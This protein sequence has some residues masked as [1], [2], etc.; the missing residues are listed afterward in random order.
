MTSVVFSIGSNLGDRAGHLR[1]AVAG[2][3][4]WA[5]CW[6]SAAST[7]RR[8]GATPT[9]RPTT[10][11]SLLVRGPSSGAEWLAAAQRIES[12]AGRAR[13]PSGASVRVPSMW[14]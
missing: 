13:D 6:R 9:S 4:R 2:S 12:D 3:R 11:R 10:T 7:R 5:S 1:F 14:I 8:R